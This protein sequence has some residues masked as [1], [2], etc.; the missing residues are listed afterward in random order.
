[1][2]LHND[3]LKAR[4]ELSKASQAV[5]YWDAMP[6]DLRGRMPALQYRAKRAEAR[7]RLRLA[8]RLCQTAASAKRA[9]DRRQATT[10]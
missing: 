4:Q 9:E 5:H 1:M 8:D 2:D 6:D 3:W 10:A 7:R